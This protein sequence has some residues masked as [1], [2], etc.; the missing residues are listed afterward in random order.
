[1]R[2]GVPSA[3]PRARTE[4]TARVRTDRLEAG[5]VPAGRRYLGGND[6]KI[7]ALHRHA[8]SLRGSAWSGPSC[9]PKSTA[10]YRA[11]L[12]SSSRAEDREGQEQ[13]GG[14]RYLPDSQRQRLLCSG[15]R[16]G[17]SL[18]PALRCPGSRRRSKDAVDY[19]LRLQSKP[20]LFR[21]FDKQSP[22]LKL[23]ERA[24]SACRSAACRQSGRGEGFRF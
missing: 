21:L 13:S 3:R 6:G 5:G 9:R 19:I 1:V 14:W 17:A 12:R 8:V 15:W 16:L 4:R 23:T 10:R 7:I 2:H 20:R 22:G 18:G 24:L 11:R